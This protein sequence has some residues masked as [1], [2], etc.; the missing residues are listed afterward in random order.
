MHNFEKHEFNFQNPNDNFS[1][2]KLEQMMCNDQFQTV[3]S[4]I[5]S[6]ITEHRPRKMEGRMEECWQSIE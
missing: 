4:K 5:A 3:R 6:L 1:F 2:F